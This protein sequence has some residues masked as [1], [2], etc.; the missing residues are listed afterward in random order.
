MRILIH[1]YSSLRRRIQVLFI[2]CY[3]HVFSSRYICSWKKSRLPSVLTHCFCAVFR[4]ASMNL[5]SR[6]FKSFQEVVLFLFH[7]KHSYWK[8][9]YWWLRFLMKSYDQ[10]HSGKLVCGMVSYLNDL[11]S[12]R[13]Q[14]QQVAVWPTLVD[15][16]SPDSLTEAYRL[17]AA[18]WAHAPAG[19]GSRPWGLLGRGLV[20]VGQPPVLWITSSE[21]AFVLLLN[22]LV[23][24]AAKNL[25]TEVIHRKSKEVAWNLTSVDL[26]RASEVSDSSPLV[27]PLR[28]CLPSSF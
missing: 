2:G 1:D 20:D 12:Q 15:I 3:S 19:L 13:I 24:I 26:V 10:V 9:V 25:Q 7:K 21:L 22:R 18:R 17:R 28:H 6:S 5:L 8:H 14:P 27:R 11:P 23:E 4:L 16:N